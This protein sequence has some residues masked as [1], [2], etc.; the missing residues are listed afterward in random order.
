LGE[1]I[2]EEGGVVA[3]VEVDEAEEVS[4]RTEAV[5]DPALPAEIVD[6][7]VRRLWIWLEWS[8]WMSRV[9]EL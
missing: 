1:R 4:D 8:I 3:A 7:T 6:M 9:S 2:G 5:S